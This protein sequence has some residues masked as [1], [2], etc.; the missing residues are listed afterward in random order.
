MLFGIAGSRMSARLRT[1][2][3]PRLLFFSETLVNR[4]LAQVF[5]ALMQQETT[6]FDD[7]KVRS[8]QP[9]HLCVLAG[10]PLF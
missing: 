4:L 2:V 9:A 3:F 10:K 7:P 1:Q 6:F 8:T 5:G